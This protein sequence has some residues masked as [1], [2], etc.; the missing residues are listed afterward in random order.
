M[1]HDARAIRFLE[2]EDRV[3]DPLFQ[4]IRFTEV[5]WFDERLAGGL[6]LAMATSH[7]FTK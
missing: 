3:C 7:F 1:L 6:V 2:G 4:L 5:L